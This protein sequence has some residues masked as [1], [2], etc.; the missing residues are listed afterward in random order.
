[1]RPIIN[2]KP[3]NQFISTIHF[4]MET[5]VN[6]E[7]R[8]YDKSGPKGCLFQYSGDKIPQKIP[9]VYFETPEVRTSMSSIWSQIIPS[10]IHKIHQ[11]VDSL[12]TITGPSR[13][14]LHRRLSLDDSFISS[15]HDSNS[16]S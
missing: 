3:L 6:S 15:K 9:S 7:E 1:M 16:G 2:L 5:N 14:D 4:K 11:T 8:L 10:S 12:S 13:L